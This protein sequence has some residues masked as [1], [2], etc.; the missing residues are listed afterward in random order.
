MH[1]L[2]WSGTAESYVD[3]NPSGVHESKAYG[4]S[5]GQQVGYGDGRALLW[6]GTSDSSVMLN[7]SGFQHSY[8][9]GISGGQ[10]VGWGDGPATTGNRAHA[11]L[12][13]G[14][15]AS[16]VDLNPIGFDESRA[17]SVSIGQQVGY[18]YG[19]S[20]GGQWHALLWSGSAESYVDLHSFLPPGYDSSCATGIDSAGSIV[21]YAITNDDTYCHAVLWKYQP[22]VIP[23]PGAIVLSGIGVG[24][25]G[26]LKRRRTL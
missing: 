8:A 17:Y 6:S 2:L 16:Y 22:D 19:N 9:C 20:T 10:Q 7:P 25:V 21:G 5:A 4:V 1:A 24:L 13:S 23:A 11:L 15:A 18:G 12:W 3:L 26:W 14:T